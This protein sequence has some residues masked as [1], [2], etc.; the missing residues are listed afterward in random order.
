MRDRVLDGQGGSPLDAVE[1]QEMFC[2]PKR[3]K[4]SRQAV[5]APTAPL[6]GPSKPRRRRWEPP[7]PRVSTSASYG[8]RGSAISISLTGHRDAHVRSEPGKACLE[9]RFRFAASRLREI[10]MKPSSPFPGAF[11]DRP[12]IQREGAA[13]GRE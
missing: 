7:P 4:E 6:T 2:S 11:E 8:K 3:D 9:V 13:G 1:V 12:I 5:E 10:A